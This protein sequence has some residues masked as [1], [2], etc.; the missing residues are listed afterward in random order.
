MPVL[1]KSY[2]G[3]PLL[4]HRIRDAWCEHSFRYATGGVVL[5]PRSNS[6]NV[7]DPVGPGGCR[8]H[9]IRTADAPRRP[10]VENSVVLDG[11]DDEVEIG[12]R[13]SRRIGIPACFMD[14]TGR[15]IRGYNGKNRR[16]PLAATKIPEE[17][18]TSIT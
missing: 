15:G 9:T 11:T 3:H 18:Y 16:R 4:H 13:G 8:P 6:G 7:A 5:A 10:A 2:R 12:R 1:S 17:P 14:C